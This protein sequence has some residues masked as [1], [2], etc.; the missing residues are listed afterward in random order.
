MRC[1]SGLVQA[2]SPKP[3]CTGTICM[4]PFTGWL[5]YCTNSFA[6]SV[7]SCANSMHHECLNTNPV[8]MRLQRKIE[9]THWAQSEHTRATSHACATCILALY[10]SADAHDAHTCASAN[11]VGAHSA[12]ELSMHRCVHQCAHDC[13]C[14]SH[15]NVAVRL[16]R[17]AHGGNMRSTPV[18]VVFSAH[19]EPQCMPL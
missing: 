16:T 5:S 13:K 8:F 2:E 1:P 11:C 17:H 14:E 9:F 18:T 4:L 7:F 10:M 19:M 15:E 12:R 6:I 3:W